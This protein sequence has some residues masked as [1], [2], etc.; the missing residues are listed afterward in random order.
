M[1]NFVYVILPYVTIIVFIAGLIWHIRTWW[2]RPRAKAVLFPAAK[3]NLVAAGKVVGDIILFG[4]T[5]S[6]SKAL[7][8]M[9][10]VFHVGLLLVVLGHIRTVTEIGFLWSWFN[11]DEE[12]I[13]SVA[14]AMGLTAGGIMLA[15]TVLLLTRRFTPNM[16]VISIFQDYFVLVM[17]LGIVLTGMS[18]RL[19]MPIHAEEVQHYARGVLTFAPAVEI[20]NNIFFWHFFL[21]QML[22]MYLPFSKLVHLIS[23]PVAESWTMR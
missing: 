12:G 6:I 3:N 10:I 16:R 4:K 20:H 5:F 13:K 22:I 21:A 15:G 14:N 11:L 8:A 7:W 23:K 18:M 9:A 1:D 17:L 2:A 19:W